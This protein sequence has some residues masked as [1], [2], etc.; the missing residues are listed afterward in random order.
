[1]NTT[2]YNADEMISIFN[3]ARKIVRY[4]VVRNIPTREGD[5]FYR[6]SSRYE[7]HPIV[8][9]A[10]KVCRPHNW[11]QLLL[12][13]PHAS[14]SDAARVA[15]T[16]DERAGVADK[17]TVTSVGKYLRRH[18]PNASDMPDHTI[19]DLVQRYGTNS[20]YKF[21]H[22]MAEML[23]HLAEG[24]GSC[25]VW[26]RSGVRCM[27]GQTRH[28]YEVYNPK[29]GWHMAV[30]VLNGETL[31]RALC[32][33][34]KQTGDKYYVR[35]YLRPAR[36]G[37]YSQVDGGLQNWLQEQGYEKKCSWQEGEKFS[38]HETRDG[39][40]L[41]PYLDGND[42]QVHAGCATGET[43]L[44]MD[45]GGSY[46]CNQTS[47]IAELEDDED[48]FECENCGDRTDNDDGYWVN[49]SEDTRVCESCRDY[50]Y[51]YVYGRRGNQYY[52]HNDYVVHCNDEYYDESYLD[53]NEIV[54]L[55]NGEYEI[56]DNA[57][58]INGDWYHVDDDRIVRAEDTDEYALLDDC[59]VC[60]ES[61][62]V[63]TDDCEDY[64]EHE[65]ERYHNDYIPATVQEAINA[66]KAAH[67]PCVGV[68]ATESTTTTTEGERP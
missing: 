1:M 47:G 65:G 67:I 25:M 8:Y 46:N 6:E 55:R 21:V 45:S 54:S 31:S 27:D 18:W 42:K 40:V 51:T 13:W 59:W 38:Y 19:R 3:D 62:R 58:E 16:R 49:R 23:H 64:I 52:V 61:G 24:P 41:M 35:T 9:A 28:P 26:S 68:S 33:H 22:T 14:L 34:N 11:Q 17:Q 50:N 15:Y 32:M 12:E 10:M 39:D 63:Y 37:E 30:G 66:E 20:E 43:Y 7:L 5:W 53:D 2:A 60:A 4:A 44:Y 57:V 56:A 29:Y 36:T 48:T